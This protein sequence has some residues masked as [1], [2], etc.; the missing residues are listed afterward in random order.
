MLSEVKKGGKMRGG[1]TKVLKGDHFVK[2]RRVNRTDYMEGPSAQC[3]GL[4]GVLTH[5]KN[6]SL[7]GGDFSGGALMGGMPWLLPIA[8]AVAPSLIGAVASKLLGSGSNGKAK[9]HRIP[10][11]VVAKIHEGVSKALIPVIGSVAKELTGGMESGGGKRTMGFEGL[12]EFLKNSRVFGGGFEGGGVLGGGFE[13]GM[14]R[15]MYMGWDKKERDMRPMWFQPEL[16]GKGFEGGSCVCPG[17]GECG[18]PKGGRRMCWCSP[19][20]K[21]KCKGGMMRGI[22]EVVHT[23]GPSAMGKH[24]GASRGGAYAKGGKSPARSAS[25]KARA[26]TNPWL[27][28]VASVRKDNPGVAYKDILKMAKKSY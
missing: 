15:P 21:C 5:S 25:A 22:G 13:G 28:H 14:M 24:L 7:Y 27:I 10:K 18:C 17:A 20:G 8:A 26:K 12:Q 6:K 3:H 11:K 19:G 2:P 9:A 1:G 16:M 23:G 4:D